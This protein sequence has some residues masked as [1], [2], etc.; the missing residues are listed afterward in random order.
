MLPPDQEATSARRD[1]T[2]LACLGITFVVVCLSG[3]FLTGM[4]I[5]L[6]QASPV[7]SYSCDG[8]ACDETSISLKGQI[9]IVSDRDGNPEIYVMNIDGSGITR[10]TDNPAGDFH[11]AWSPDGTRIA[12]V[13]GSDG[14]QEIYVMGA[15]GSD[16]TRLTNDPAREDRKSVV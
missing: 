5:W 4:G 10:L 12:F 6:L 8:D 7:A 14:N 13:S 15:D 11:P 1:V 2:P 9:A 3:L 16:V